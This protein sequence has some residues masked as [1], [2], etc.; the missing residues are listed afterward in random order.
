MSHDDYIY[1]INWN[2]PRVSPPGSLNQQ[3]PGKRDT[4]IAQETRLAKA[5]WLL[6]EV[7]EHLRH[8]IDNKEAQTLLQKI[9]EEL[10]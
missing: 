3:P 2:N 7:K 10:Q 5:E 9:E 4:L 6:G 1:S 8:Q